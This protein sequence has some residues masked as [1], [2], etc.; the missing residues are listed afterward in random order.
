M[1]TL[2]V[3]DDF[4]SRLILQKVL[5][6]SGEAHIAVNGAEALEAFKA[7]LAGREPY[8]LV[9]LDIMMPEMDGQEV[10]SRLR[11]AETAAGVPV[12]AG[13]KIVMTTALSDAHNVT[14]AF[15]EQCEAYLV[16]PVEPREL[17]AKLKELGLPAES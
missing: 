9:C 5:S 15:R 1:K 6:A 4:T 16:K 10:L 8:D 2:I 14:R 13:S 11:A 17:R 3:D 7:A 12:N